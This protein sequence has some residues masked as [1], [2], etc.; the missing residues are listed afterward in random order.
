MHLERATPADL[1]ALHALIESAYRGESARRG[2][3]H[4]ADLL[5]GQR[6]DL[7]ALESMLG[8]P[9]QL[10]LVFRDGDSLRACVSL[11]DKGDRIAYL[12]LLTVDP[13]R[14]ASGLG[15]LILAAAEDQAAEHFGATRVEMSVIAQRAELIAWYE[16]RGY[17]LTDERRPFP[18]DDPRFGLPRRSDLEFVVL[19]KALT[20]V[21]LASP[22]S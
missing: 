12:G 19:E 17:V 20:S 3:S 6:T 5:E 21:G 7:A 1:P 10:L 13:K 2:W 14:Q 22:G 9:C 18:N 15:R 16:R 4:E 8:D 11:T